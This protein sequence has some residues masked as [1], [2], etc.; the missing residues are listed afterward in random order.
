MK[1]RLAQHHK[2]RTINGE[3]WR[4]EGIVY[5]HVRLTGQLS[6]QQWNVRNLH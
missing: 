2:N 5:S 3:N 4:D 1:E 6:S